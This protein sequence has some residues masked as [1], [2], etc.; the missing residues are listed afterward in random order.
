MESNK[1]P[2][3]KINILCHDFGKFISI[4]LNTSSDS[5]SLISQACF[6]GYFYIL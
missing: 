3:N 6:P 2:S 1:F 5:D 4:C